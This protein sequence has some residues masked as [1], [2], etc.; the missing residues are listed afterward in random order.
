M[1]GIRGKIRMRGNRGTRERQE[2]D[3]TVVYW[4]KLNLIKRYTSVPG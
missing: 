4:A 2:R 3:D 1:R